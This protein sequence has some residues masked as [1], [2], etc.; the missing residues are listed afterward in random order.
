MVLDAVPNSVVVFEPGV[1]GADPT[2]GHVAWV[3]TVQD[4]PNG[5]MVTFIEMNGV[6]G[7]GQYNE[8]TVVNQI[9]TNYIPAPVG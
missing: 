8:L 5:R 3:T 7:P 2:Y 6:A 9:G 4:T 1:A